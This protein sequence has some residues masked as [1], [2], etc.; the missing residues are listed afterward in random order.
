MLALKRTRKEEKK[1]AAAILHFEQAMSLPNMVNP[2]SAAK[3]TRAPALHLAAH[4]VLK[5]QKRPK[6]VRNDLES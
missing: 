3:A 1:A 2:T 5:G 6:K 4:L